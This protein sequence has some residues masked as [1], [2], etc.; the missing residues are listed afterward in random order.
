M[1][2]RRRPTGVSPSTWRRLTP[3]AQRRMVRRAAL[4]CAAEGTPDIRTLLRRRVLGLTAD[5]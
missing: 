3:L 1:R 5:V 4:R 2:R